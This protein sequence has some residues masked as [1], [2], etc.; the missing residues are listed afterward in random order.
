MKVKTV[1][2]T[3]LLVGFL[4]VIAVGLMIGKDML[5]KPF[6]ISHV[7]D[8]Y[9]SF[10]IYGIA[11]SLVI[12]L[13]LSWFVRRNIPPLLVPV[14]PS[15]IFPIT[16]WAVYQIAFFLSDGNVGFERSDLSPLTAEI[17]LA[18]A[19]LRYGTLGSFVSLLVGVI[20]VSITNRAKPM[21]LK[22]ES[23]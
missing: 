19:L 20:A 3:S 4:I 23:N 1:R 15:L 2:T 9:A 11:I 16:L 21:K 10:A 22:S 18:Y 5:D 8:F 17:E 14:F 6:K 13:A 12:A 7:A